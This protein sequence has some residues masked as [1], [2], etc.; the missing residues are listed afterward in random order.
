MTLDA[1]CPVALL[2]VRVETRLD[3]TSLQLRIYPDEIFADTH[4][5]ELTADESADGA[6]YLAAAQAGTAAEQAAWGQ[7]V[8]RWTAPRAA[9][10]ALAAAGTVGARAD[11]W[12]RAAEATLPDRWLVRAY[13]GAD[14][15]TLTSGPV[16]KPLALTL[17]PSATDADRVPLSDGLTIDAALLWT[18]DFA[19]AEAAGMAVEIDLTKPDA[20]PTTPAP[21]PPPQGVDMILVIGVDD[22]A[23]PADG[24][25][26]L[27]ALLDAQHYTR[28]IAFMAPGTPTNNTPG[29][30]V[31]FPPPD[32]GGAVSFAVER[33]APLVGAGSD[34]GVNG[35]LFAGALG[36]GTDTVAHVAGAGDHGDDAAAAMNDALWPATFGYFMEQLMTPRFSSADIEAARA[37]WVAHV[38]PG[39][40]LPALRVGGVPYGLLPAAS[41]DRQPAG[42]WIATLTALRDRYFVPAVGG[43][44]QIAANSSDPDGD[45]LQVLAVDASAR[46]ARAR[47]LLG[48]QLTT[49]T[50]DWLGTTIAAQ[51]VARQRL[52][53]ASASSVL[54]TLGQPATTRLGT[55]DPGPRDELI[56]GPLV[57]P[58]PAS[59]EYGL[60]GADGSGFNYITWLHDNALSGFAAIRDDAPPTG[61]R[62]LLYRLLRHALLT[63][64]DRLAFQG[65][66]IQ[67]VVIASQRAEVELVNLTPTAAQLT[68]YQRI[69]QAL[70]DPGFP[71][72]I[73]PYLATLST[74]AA[75]PTA[76]L[77]RRFGETLDACSHRLDAWVTA[78][79]TEQL[80]GLRAA[81]P[82]GCYVG[83]FGWVENVQP[84][85]AGATPGGYVQA[86]SSAHAATAAI[87]RNG[88]LSRGGAG[89]PYDVD[90]GSARVRAALELIDGTRQG[91]P[92][93]A[94]LGQRFE[95]DLHARELDLLI[96]PLRSD[97]PLVAGKTPEGDGPVEM[98]A[99]TNVV[100]GLAL[101]AA[102]NAGAAPFAPGG[103]L[104]TLTPEQLDG[105]QAALGAL[106][107][108][109][110]GVAD[111]LTAESIF[112]AVRGNPMAAA[113][114]LDTMGQGAQPPRPAVASTPLAGASFTQRL[115][116]VLDASAT[117]AAGP[118][119]ERTPRAA[120]EPFLDDWL[121]TLAGP[122]NG[123]GCAVA[124]PDG[125]TQEVHADALSLR[126]LDLLALA[127][128]PP[129]GS[130]DGELDRRVL[131]AAAAPP[132]ATIDYDSGG[133]ALSFAQALE[134]LRAAGDLLAAARPLAPAD[135][136][137]PGDPGTPAPTPVPATDRAQAA[138]DALTATAA[139][140]DAALGEPPDPA[141][142]RAALVG[143][144]ALGVT[145]AY[146][147]GDADA[148]ALVVLA[149]AAGSEIAA[150]QAG[151][152]TSADPA[153][154][155]QAVFGRDFLFLPALVA[156][157]LDQPLDGPPLADPKPVRQTLQ[158]L[159]RV[160]PGLASWRAL[161]LYGQALG[162][163][164]PLVDV[165]QLPAATTWAGSPGASFGPGT[166]SL[167]LHRPTGAPAAQGW[168]GFVVDEWNETVPAARQTTVLA[169]RHSAPVAQAPQAILLAVPPPGATTWDPEALLDIV[170]ETLTMA[171]LRGVDGSQLESLRPF[172]PAIC[173]TGNTANDAISTDL[174]SALVAEP[175]IEVG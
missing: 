89:S 104:P 1:T 35:M 106:D 116:V 134:L 29:V 82:A 110:D 132:G 66:L 78:L 169:F 37:F 135:L 131:D 15:F 175:R 73:A 94:L 14:T 105:L 100:D 10:I 164:A 36:L 7:L 122:P 113:A 20:P 64:M 151:A 60:E 145:G 124:L 98:V 44:P 97:F 92:L 83:A 128:T 138:L 41:L 42:A 17:S 23:M 163:P 114:T 2:P 99:A 79:A 21:P 59:E 65:L 71:A 68:S 39:G 4:E 26:Q 54:S 47:V 77:E 24:A 118:W 31:A 149:G 148:D 117:P 108:A 137:A 143:A 84:A 67:G 27:A 53:E 52:R 173:M 150:R 130:G 32:P 57:S 126:P 87:L 127:R 49:N 160:R 95:R 158:Q 76:E 22:A 140:L 166:L 91:E 6:A 62:P 161:W 152:P 81:A 136:I 9:Y 85:A 139:A 119:G 58:E 162:Q 159:A 3:G 33:G 50:A 112:Q 115:A 11:T 18:V 107:D 109:V 63:E 55:L 123:I 101:R 19:E 30:A 80:S 28:G 133:G 103:D 96:A 141:A 12:T 72:R 46:L 74:L 69:G 156:P 102:W 155:V 8:A 167:L 147:P 168:A 125:T 70:P 121:A 75:L 157:A 170:R 153:G 16:R 90:L 43:V 165:V 5:P 146:P 56:G 174:L 86:P 111:L 25:T 142:L 171:K 88:Y 172:L 48:Q 51:E 129:S 34:P 13:A 120:V 144:A 45:L 40:P 154:A 38:R 93:A 61:V